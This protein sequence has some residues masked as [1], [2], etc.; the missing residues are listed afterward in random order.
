MVQM[1]WSAAIAWRPAGGKEYELNIS[2][3]E[4]NY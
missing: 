3:N 1:K 2:W 4:Q